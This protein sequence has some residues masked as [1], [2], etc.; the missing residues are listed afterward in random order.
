MARTLAQIKN[1]IE[2][3]Q[4]EAESVKHREVAGVVSRIQEAIAFYGL[5]PAD[6]FGAGEKKA[7]G[8]KPGAV[9]AAKKLAIKKV[10]VAKFRDDASGKT[11]TGH[12]KRPTWF[13][14]ALAAGKTPVDLTVKA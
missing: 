8:A 10:P 3:L 5:V 12:G 13:V 7:R 14:N 1:E 4:K 11:W 6:L 2:K 9:A